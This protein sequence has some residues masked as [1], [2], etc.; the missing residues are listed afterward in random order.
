[1]TDRGLEFRSAVRL[2]RKRLGAA[3]P[4]D[5][6]P[7]DL[8]QRLHTSRAARQSRAVGA[9]LGEIDGRIGNLEAAAT[10]RHAEPRPRGGTLS[11]AR[12]RL[13]TWRKNVRQG[14]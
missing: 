13:R 7:A 1:M 10:R 14:R 6:P 11:R 3:L 9:K 5:R 2:A 8:G 4:A 12:A